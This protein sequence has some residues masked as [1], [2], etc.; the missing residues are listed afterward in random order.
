[1]PRK[2]L[3]LGRNAGSLRW[4]CNYDDDPKTGDENHLAHCDVRK[5][6]D[7]LK[8]RGYHIDV[9]GPEYKDEAD[10]LKLVKK[11]VRACAH[12]DHFLFYFSGHVRIKEDNLELLLTGDWPPE[13]FLSSRLIDLLQNDCNA[14]T[15]LLILDCCYAEIAK[16]PWH[17]KRHDNLRFLISTKSN[18]PGKEVDGLK[19]GIFTHCLCEALTQAEYWRLDAP[20]PLVDADGHI[21]SD[22][23]LTWLKHRIRTVGSLHLPGANFPEPTGDAGQDEPFFIARVEVPAPVEVPLEVRDLF[24][25]DLPTIG[26]SEC[27]VHEKFTLFG[28][29]PIDLSIEFTAIDYAV[30]KH[31][32]DRD[33]V[34]TLCETI[35]A[36]GARIRSF[37][38]SSRPG[39]GLS[40]ALAQLVRDLSL[41]AVIKLFW[42]ID[43]PDRTSRVLFPRLSKEMADS[44]YSHISACSPRVEH[45]VIILDD[46]SKAPSRTIHNLI[47]FRERCKHLANERVGPRVTFIFG[48]FGDTHPCSED[49][50]FALKLTINDRERC[51]QQM[52][53]VEPRILLWTGGLDAILRAYPESRWYENDAQAFIDFLLQHGQPTREANKHWLARTEGL[54][55]ADLAIFTTTAVAQLIDLPIEEAVVKRLFSSPAREPLQD[56][57]Q[58]VRKVRGLALIQQDWKGLG[59]SCARRARSI[60]ERTNTLRFDFLC[61]T[62][63]EFVRESLEHFQAD[64]H[65]AHRTLEFAR[66]IFQR[67][68]KEPLYHFND[69]KR[70]A[71]YLC[72]IHL[73]AL[74]AAS[75][76]WNGFE[77]AR[78][79]GT[80]S[81]V[82][83]PVK[84]AEPMDS[85]YF[86][87]AICV[88]CGLCEDAFSEYSGDASSPPPDAALS[89]YRASRLLLSLP[90]PHTSRIQ[91]FCFGLQYGISTKDFWNI[92]DQ[93]LVSDVNDPPYRANALFHARSKFEDSVQGRP[94]ILRINE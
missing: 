52:T 27:E 29:R 22:K 3:L 7:A 14:H 10:V 50:T 91:K 28:G 5:M 63:S 94:H 15:K 85:T 44:F 54:D 51:Y 40:L 87:K 80:L 24:S 69:D 25:T 32:F 2:A 61:K 31:S 4:C 36:P 84:G 11:A 55:G 33:L 62:F 72:R 1:M 74:I 13:T 37:T 30:A 66:H 23:L 39:A 81:A 12:E 56:V 90:T 73:D 17:P 18:L 68:S 75:D 76:R 16:N 35:R 21:Y 20:V 43:D 58:V 45:A 83:A 89:L 64:G 65:G 71:Q 53:S 26:V 19:G 92:L 59:L 47:A 57:E 6:R 48:Y 60:L 77:R 86:S 70:I 9:A 38:I 79:A 46:V 8:A 88:I 93:L 49:D 78:W 82:V 42:V 41:D 67:L 34:A